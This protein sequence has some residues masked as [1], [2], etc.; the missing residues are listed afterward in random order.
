MFCIDMQ[1]P[2]DM[3]DTYQTKSKA[4]RNNFSRR[5]KQSVKQTAE[6]GG[7]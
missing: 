2:Y 7:Q 3:M 6:S 5:R 4:K 1:A